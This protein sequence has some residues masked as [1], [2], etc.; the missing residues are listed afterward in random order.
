M[1]AEDRRH[2]FDRFWRG[3]ASQPG[4]GSGLGLSIVHQLA[5]TSGA[6]VELREAAGGGVDAVVRMAAASVR[7]RDLE[8]L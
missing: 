4:S 7:P 8:P 5:R 6:E 2:A 1:G 3:T